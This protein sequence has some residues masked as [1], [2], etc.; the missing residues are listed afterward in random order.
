MMTYLPG[1]VLWVGATIAPTHSF[2]LVYCSTGF[3][4]G[5]GQGRLTNSFIFLYKP[6]HAATFFLL[7]YVTLRN[8]PQL[9]GNLV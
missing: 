8:S 5:T 7:P 6:I 3:I 9:T 1:S 4:V 2:I